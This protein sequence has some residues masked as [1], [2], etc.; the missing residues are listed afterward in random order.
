[1]VPPEFTE[2]TALGVAYAAGLAVGFWTDLGS[3]KR[4]WKADRQWEP[5]W[6]DDQREAAYDGWRKAVDRS[7]G[8]VEDPPHGSV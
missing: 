8:W 7:F 3:L 4:H 1:V 5:T 6:S 2:T